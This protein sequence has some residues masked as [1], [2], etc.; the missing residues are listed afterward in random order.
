MLDRRNIFV[1][2]LKHF[3][4]EAMNMKNG[5]CSFWDEINCIISIQASHFFEEKT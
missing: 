4:Y 1:H 2:L 3:F 5:V